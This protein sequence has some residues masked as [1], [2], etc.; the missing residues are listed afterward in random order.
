MIR[1]IIV[2]WTIL[3]LPMSVTADRKSSV[4]IKVISFMAEYSRLY[5]D[6]NTS[7]ITL[8]SLF[9]SEIREFYE[10]DQLR[11]SRFTGPLLGGFL[12]APIKIHKNRSVKIVDCNELNLTIDAD[13]CVVVSGEIVIAGKTAWEYKPYKVVLGFVEQNE[14]YLIG[15]IRQGEPDDSGYFEWPAPPWE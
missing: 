6:P 15:Y 12:D 4:G 2:L 3:F 10:S 13:A 8:V 11:K 5:Q 7:V 14:D 1:R 9:T